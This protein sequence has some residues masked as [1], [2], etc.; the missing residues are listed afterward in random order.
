MQQVKAII[1]ASQ[2]W[3]GNPSHRIVR[4]SGAICEPPS[5]IK[6]PTMLNAFR[7]E[8]ASSPRFSMGCLSLFGRSALASLAIAGASVSTGSRA[9]PN[10]YAALVQRVAPSVVTIMVE[11]Q[12][13]NAADR[14]AERAERRAEAE[15]DPNAVNAILRGLLSAQADGSKRDEQGTDA[16]GSGFVIREDGLIVTNRR[17]IAGARRVRVRVGDGRELE[18]TIVGS[19]A[20]TDIALLKVA[21]G[22]LLPLRL[23]SS[24]HI[25]V[26]DAVIAIGN[27][28]GLGQ[29]VSAGIISARG[30]VLEDD[31]YI[32]FLQTDAAINRGNSGGPLVTVNGEVVGVTS[33]IFSPSGGSVGLGFATRGDCR[34]SRPRP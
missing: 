5:H 21:G 19:D 22:P 30:R 15:A 29:S 28:Y 25:A 3:S 7:A 4:R 12:Q 33:A 34:G 14:A 26:G 16:L 8:C 23:G 13:V 32:D 20:V 17:V 10:G 1:A 9:E 18:A 31:P 6:W 2:A 27:P 24:Q 11:G